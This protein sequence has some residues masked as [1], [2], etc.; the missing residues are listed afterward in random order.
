MSS[1]VQWPMA[2]KEASQESLGSVLVAVVIIIYT[3]IPTNCSYVAIEEVPNTLYTTEAVPSIHGHV[4][5]VSNDKHHV[6]VMD[7]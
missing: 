2:Y 5:R 4:G 1:T 7:H 6:T 3:I